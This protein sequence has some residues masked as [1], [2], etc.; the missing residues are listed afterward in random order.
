MWMA[1]T[2]TPDGTAKKVH[3]PQSRMKREKHHNASAAAA[4]LSMESAV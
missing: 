3:I 4:T 1:V 2:E